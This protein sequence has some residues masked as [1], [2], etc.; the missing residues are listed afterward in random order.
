MTEA[1]EELKLLSVLNTHE[2]TYN[3]ESDLNSVKQYNRELYDYFIENNLESIDDFKKEVAIIT[4]ELSQLSFDIRL[5]HYVVWKKLKEKIKFS[6]F[7]INEIS[8]WENSDIVIHH[9][10]YSGKVLGF[11]HDTCNKKLRQTI[12]NYSVCVYAY[13]SRNFDL[14]FILPAINLSER[15]TLKTSVTSKSGVETLKICNE[16]EF[17]AT[18]KFFNSSLESLGD[19]ADDN[20]KKDILKD[21]EKIILNHPKFNAIYQL[22]S[23][24]NKEKMLRLLCRKGAIPYDIFK[25]GYEL[26]NINCFLSRQCFS[27]M[28]KPNV[29]ISESTYQNVKDIWNSFNCK[30]LDELNY[31]YNMT[32]VILLTVL[33]QN[34]FEILKNLMVFEPKNFS[35]LSTFS[36]ASQYLFN[37]SM[38]SLPNDSD[39][40]D[41]FEKSI[42]GGFVATPIPV[43]LLTVAL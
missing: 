2:L 40:V 42:I 37:K 41:S 31:L 17:R 33:C 7:F 9:D 29:E 30:N 35:S 32:D 6:S 23:D 38:T 20:E 15:G 28:L 1:Y 3:L 14:K 13:I 24:K 25:D 5:I 16:V 22:K 39:V 11:A 8:E 4:E 36:K 12:N 10:Y 19:S 43:Y 26:E 18:I 27:S 34:R 21:I